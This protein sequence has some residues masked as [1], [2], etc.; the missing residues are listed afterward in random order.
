MLDRLLVTDVGCTETSVYNYQS[1]PRNIPE[2]RRSR[3]V[4]EAR[5]HAGSLLT[6]RPRVT[7]NTRFHFISLREPGDS[8]ELP[9]SCLILQAC[10]QL[11]NLKP[12]TLYLAQLEST[13]L[14]WQNFM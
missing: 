1:T 3:T 14:H 2:E 8:V 12:R 6:N 4:T 9:Y 7:S 13:S 10:S 11:H 5:Y